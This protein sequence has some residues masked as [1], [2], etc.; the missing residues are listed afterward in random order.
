[1]ASGATLNG[2]RIHLPHCAQP[3]FYPEVAR[4]T[5]R[6]KRSLKFPFRLEIKQEA[7][8]TTAEKNEQ[9]QRLKQQAEEI[10]FAQCA[11]IV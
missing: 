6:K 3:N 7:S 1:L 5:E 8:E 4:N 10:L 9:K 11:A 2:N